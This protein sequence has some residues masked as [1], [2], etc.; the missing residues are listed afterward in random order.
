MEDKLKLFQS[1]I[2]MIHIFSPILLKGVFGLGQL[3]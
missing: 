2:E 1:E 3:S